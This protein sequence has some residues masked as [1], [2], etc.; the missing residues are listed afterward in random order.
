MPEQEKPERVESRSRF[1]RFIDMTFFLYAGLVVY[2]GVRFLVF[3]EDFLTDANENNV[4]IALA[5]FIPFVSAV[6]T[7]SVWFDEELR[8]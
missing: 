2:V 7:L 5:L 4:V 3:G 8:K 6:Y 1:R